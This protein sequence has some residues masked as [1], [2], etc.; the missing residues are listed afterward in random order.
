MR[1]RRPHRGWYGAVVMVEALAA[2]TLTQSALRFCRFQ[3]VR[4]VLQAL[5]RWCRTNRRVESAVL[6]W[7]MAAAKRRCPI[8][9]TCL[10]EALVA[11][12]L[13]SQHGYRPT[14]CIGAARR[15]GRFEAHAWLEQDNAVVIGGPVEI[16]QQYS[17]FPEIASL[18]I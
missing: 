15:E 17:R 16:V 4:Q 6:L 9:T 7:A 8:R 14:L 3:H 5:G 1:L 13:L 2:L 10:G 18:N 11:E 12:A